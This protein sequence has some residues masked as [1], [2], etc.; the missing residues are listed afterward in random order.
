M[1]S[2]HS[3]CPYLSV[4]TQ[5]Q[6]HKWLRALWYLCMAP[7]LHTHNFILHRSTWDWEESSQRPWLS[8][9]SS[10]YL[11]RDDSSWHPGSNMLAFTLSCCDNPREVMK[12]QFESP[13]IRKST[14]IQRSSL[15]YSCSWSQQFDV[16][17]Y[18]EHE[19]Q[20]SMWQNKQNLSK[21]WWEVLTARNPS[22]KRA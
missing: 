11:L 20:Q 17:I 8:E 12:C 19:I 13:Y 3:T 10:F 14:L 1:V 2:F 16:C 5:H 4:S 6:G 22:P 7:T 21:W 15:N 9:P 18:L